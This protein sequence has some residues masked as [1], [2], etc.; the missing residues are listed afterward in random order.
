MATHLVERGRR[1]CDRALLLDEGQLV[2]S[3][4]A[5]EMPDDALRGSAAP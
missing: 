4:P 3:G 5:A 2:W 1:L